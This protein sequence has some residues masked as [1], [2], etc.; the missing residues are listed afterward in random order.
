MDQQ[1]QNGGVLI[2]FRRV[3]FHASPGAVFAIKKMAP[4][5]IAGG[6]ILRPAAAGWRRTKT[7][8]TINLKVNP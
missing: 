1:L 8:V 2:F 6:E 3:K 5:F 7:K 4:G